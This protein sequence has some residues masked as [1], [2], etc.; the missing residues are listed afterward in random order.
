MTDVKF[1]AV[2]DESIGR[3]VDEFYTKVRA[4]PALCTIECNEFS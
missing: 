1:A 3:L 4:D 2:T